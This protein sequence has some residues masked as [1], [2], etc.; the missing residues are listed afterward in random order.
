[1][2]ACVCILETISADNAAQDLNVSAISYS[3]SGQLIS[4]AFLLLCVYLCTCVFATN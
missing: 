3:L 2:R 4:L 1:M